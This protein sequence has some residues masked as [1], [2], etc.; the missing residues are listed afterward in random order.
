EA[1]QR[2]FQR[3]PILGQYIWPNA[4]VG[5]TYA[6]EID[7]LKT[8]LI[9]RGRWMDGQLT[10]IDHQNQARVFSVNVFPNPFNSRI[11]I[12]LDLPQPT[13]LRATV[14]NMMGNPITDF[15]NGPAG[16]G[17]YAWQ[18]SGENDSGAEV[19]SGCYF[20]ILQT[21]DER[22]VRPLIILR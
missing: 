7:Y 11:T 5:K 13:F 8:W 20:L 16:A 15:F 14:Y 4:F 9:K 6:E 22:L 1:Q 12:V 18:W 3:W 10:G 2:N 21:N 19:P 17:Q